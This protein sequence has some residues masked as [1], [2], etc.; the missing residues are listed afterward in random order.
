M[1]KK[2]LILILLLVTTQA[3]SQY[4]IYGGAS[5][6]SPFGA[7]KLFYGFNLGTEIPKD[8]ETSLY[9]RMSFFNKRAEVGTQSYL[10]ENIDSTDYSLHFVNGYGT[11]NYTTFEG[12]IRRYLG[13][14]D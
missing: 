11:F 5:V 1:I 10:L 14:Y 3:N 12:G 4:S 8:D 9:L 13:G 2:S 7:N 6:L